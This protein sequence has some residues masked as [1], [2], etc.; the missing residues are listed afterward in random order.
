MEVSG[1][2][3]GPYT[4]KY[5]RLTVGAPKLAAYAR[6]RSSAA[7]LVTPYGLCG[8]PDRPGS[9]DALRGT[10]HRLVVPRDIGACPWFAR[11]AS[12]TRHPSRD[13]SQARSS[14]GTSALCPWFARQASLTRRPTPVRRPTNWRR[15]R[16]GRPGGGA[17]PPAVTGSRRCCPASGGQIRRPGGAN[18]GLARQV[19]VDVHALAQPVQRLRIGRDQ[20]DPGPTEPKV[21]GR[22]RRITRIDAEHVPAGVR[23]RRPV[24]PR[25]TGCTGDQSPHRAG[26]PDPGKAWL[27]DLLLMVDLRLPDRCR[28]PGQVTRSRP[29]GGVILVIPAHDEAGRIGP[30]DRTAAATVLGSR[31]GGSSWTTARPTTRPSRR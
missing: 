23:G 8:M 20:I 9:P 15:T 27:P 29:R 16:I 13:T 5:R 1:R 7:S 12:L 4:V 3:P 18:A 21:P 11:Q 17:R 6:R 26:L 31:P 25:R 19:E 14:R 22:R 10:P 30:A 24:R 2:W 28:R